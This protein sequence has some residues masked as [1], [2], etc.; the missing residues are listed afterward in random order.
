M[1]TWGTLKT[2]IQKLLN[3]ADF[4]TGGT[5]EAYLLIW[6]NRLVKNIIS[7][8]ELR[9]F[10][11]TASTAITTANYIF[12]LPTDFWKVSDIYTK[13]RVGD[14]YIDI[15]P[16]DT[17]NENDPDHSDTTTATLPDEVSIENGNLYVYPKIACTI[18]IENYLRENTDIALITE[19]PDMP[20]LDLLD[21]VIINGVA[22]YGFR[23]L[24]EKGD[25][26]KL[27]QLEIAKMECDRALA[28]YKKHIRE[29]DRFSSGSVI[30]GAYGV[31]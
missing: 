22:V 3:S 1:A 17:L 18:V 11:K 8:N 7:A 24:N 26:E 14:I 31:G 29:L 19:S 5:D 16:L 4:D 9:Y 20:Y 2:E 12:S 25:S 10:L 21:D 6:A 23:W 28:L 27:G 15:V 13:I 30:E